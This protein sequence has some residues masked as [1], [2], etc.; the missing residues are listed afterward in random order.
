MH[1]SQFCRLSI[2]MAL[3]GGALLGGA[4]AALAAPANDQRG[5]AE[6]LGAP[7]L[8]VRGTTVDATTEPGEPASCRG[9]S[10]SSVWYE[11][12]S[13]AA[14]PLVVVLKAAGDLD[15]VVDV[16]QRT[17]SQL[18]G[19]GCAATNRRGEAILDFDRRAGATYL[20]RVAALPNSA[21][22]AFSLTIAQPDEPA[23]RP[24]RALRRS[25]ANGTLDRITNPDDAWAFRLRPG[26]SYR[27]NLH[28]RGSRCAVA[29]LYAPGGGFG[30]PMRSL[31]CNQ[32]ALV[33]PAAG[34]G[35]TYTLRPVAP[36]ASRGAIPYHVQVA[37]AGRDDTA[38]GLFVG[39]DKVVRG[40]L[41]GS[42]VDVVDLYRFDVTRPSRLDLQLRT[43]ESNR[44]DLRLLSSGGRRIACACGSSGT[45]QIERRLPP[46]RYFA[47]VRARHGD[48]GSYRLFRLS[49]TITK[50]H[51]TIDGRR[52]AQAAPGQ[53]VTIAADVAPGASGPVTVD[54]ERF[55]P[56]AGWQFFSRRRVHA[57]G[58]RAAFAFVP[59]SIG[60]WRVFARFDGTRRAS[61]SG[62]SRATLVVAGPLVD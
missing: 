29:E 15:A 27:V 43:G 54:I 25:G 45:Q 20:L 50:T 12:R 42:R 3:A 23:S 58:G 30:D 51:V 4:S 17:R 37:R 28:S 56:L 2:A 31:R 44:F 8:T 61:P 24:G 14:R 34:E 52:E 9:E 11:L 40:T 49:R 48:N 33:T 35:G 10:T 22:D 62:P 7:P 59:P 38:P 53:S 19:I 55:D 32:Y 41:R 13:G 36:R 47:A 39:N 6:A 60:R 26:R 18:T 16:F 5:N 57:A 21:T 1:P 46:G